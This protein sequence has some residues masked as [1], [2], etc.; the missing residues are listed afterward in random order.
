MTMKKAAVVAICSIIF[1]LT[2]CHTFAQDVSLTRDQVSRFLRDFPGFVNAAQKFD[3]VKAETASDYLAA[4]ITAHEA[5]AY[6]EKRGWDPNAFFPIAQRIMQAFGAIKVEESKQEGAVDMQQ[7]RQA[8]EAALNDP[9]LTP[10]MKAMLEQNMAQ[11]EKQWQQDPF[12]NVPEA[13]IDLVRPFA[14]RI[15]AMLDMLA[16]EE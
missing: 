13:D 8:M 6:L 9:S 7:A 3:N 5:I 15:E 2:F 11:L 16:F 14:P 4:Q 1:I 12:K 10:E